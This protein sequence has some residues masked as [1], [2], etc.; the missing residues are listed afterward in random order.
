MVVFLN[1]KTS[2]RLTSVPLSDVFET[3]NV[4]TET[5]IR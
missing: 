2:V 5:E 1:K 4:E 3:T